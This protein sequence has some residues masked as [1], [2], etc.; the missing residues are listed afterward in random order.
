M[1][2]I[3]KIGIAGAG[4]CALVLG[5]VS[6][7]F[8]DYA[9]GSG[10]VVGVGSDT[11]QNIMDFVADGDQNSDGGYNTTGNI[12]K[13]VSFD[14]TP[15]S[16]DRAG[17]LNGSSNGASLKPLN[18]TIVLRGNTTPVP[19][20]N[21]SGAG[22]TALQ[23]DNGAVEKIN[24]VRLSAAP[25]AA[26]E[27]AFV[28]AQGTQLHTVQIAQD[29]L[30][31][32]YASAATNVPAAGLSIAQLAAI[33][34]CADTTWDQVYAGGPHEA[35]DALLPQA[36]SGTRN[37]FLTD[38]L[39]SKTPSNLCTTLGIVEE[40]DPTAITSDAHPQDA[41]VPFSAGRLALFNSSP[42]AYFHDPAG[43]GSTVV[44]GI[45]LQQGFQSDGT[46]HRVSSDGT[47][48]VYDD[49]RGLYITFRDRDTTD[50]PWQPGGTKNWVNTL[51]VG[52]NSYV[53]KSSTQALISS[54]GAIPAYV[55]E[56]AGF[57]IH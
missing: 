51:F 32:A 22:L 34:T 5:L 1:R 50:A 6:P 33:Y 30:E 42:N 52:T 9:P 16:N 7:A 28:T 13:L 8:A 24:F 36:N 18:P 37:T 4:A 53:A 44:A 29:P 55:D 54:A 43:T 39:G 31:I 10:D 12:N 11:V 45:S 15:D 46:T 23:N 49:V 14:A 20:P 56:G 41:L 26:Q 40:N 47:N 57:T 21:G 35:I 25:T 2:R 27:S 19:R 3:K 38:I 48:N 17:Y